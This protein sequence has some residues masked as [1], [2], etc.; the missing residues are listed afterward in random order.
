M[1][2]IFVSGVLK[3]PAQIQMNAQGY[4]LSF[5]MVNYDKTIDDQGIVKQILTSWK[6]SLPFAKKP[7]Q[8]LKKLGR[9][10]KVLVK[11]DAHINHKEID[12]QFKLECSLL[13]EQ[14]DILG[15]ESIVDEETAT[16][17]Q[18]EDRT[19]VAS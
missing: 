13:A 9:G 8:M 19:A 11:G 12:N 18:W 14:L 7:T 17:V 6:V 5:D 4:L 16:S 3:T 15:G 2:T 1:N 10:I